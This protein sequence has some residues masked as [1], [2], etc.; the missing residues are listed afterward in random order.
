MVVRYDIEFLRTSWVD[1]EENEKNIRVVDIV[2]GEGTV[3]D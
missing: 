3:E 1:G 2:Q